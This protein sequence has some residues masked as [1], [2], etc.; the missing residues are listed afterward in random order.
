MALS[1][2][3]VGAIMLTLILI[4]LLILSIDFDRARFDQTPEFNAW[5]STRRQTV[6]ALADYVQAQRAVEARRLAASPDGPVIVLPAG[7]SDSAR[8][9]VL[10]IAQQELRGLPERRTDTRVILLER[11]TTYFTSARFEMYTNAGPN[12]YCLATYPVPRLT[13]QLQRGVFARS[14]LDWT[15]VGGPHVTNVLGPCA[16]WAKYGPPGPQISRW[17]RAGGYRY[18][19][20]KA[21][22]LQPHRAQYAEARGARGYSVMRLVYGDWTTGFARR[23]RAGDA[24]SCLDT[25]LRPQ[26]RGEWDDVLG[27]LADYTRGDWP[28]RSFGFGDAALL[29]HI[30]RAFGAQRFEQFWRSNEDVPAAFRSAFGVEPGWWL[31]GWAVEHYGRAAVGPGINLVTVALSLMTLVALA[32]LAAYAGGRRT[33]A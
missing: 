16:F 15:N 23:C 5:V 22:W 21:E 9:A 33:V 27:G 4:T 3:W 2:K 10:S 29:A 11:D 25:F 26:V 19:D 32:G 1:L 30:E 8:A 14:S 7:L 12:P 13:H 18:A 31:A 17:L 6:Q 28:Y 24:E 20:G